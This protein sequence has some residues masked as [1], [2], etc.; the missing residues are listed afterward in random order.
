MDD[1]LIFS[2]DLDTHQKQTVSIL[3]RL[4]KQDLYLK[5]EKCKF[6][7]QEVDFLRLIVKPNK[8]PRNEPYQIKR[9]SWLACPFYSETGQVIPWIWKLL[10]EI[11]WKWHDL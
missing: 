10:Q 9:N 8:L 3:K 11:Y 6:D 2:K 4:E 5:A 7:C 1:M